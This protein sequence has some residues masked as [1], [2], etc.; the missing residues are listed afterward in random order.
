MP[1]GSVAASSTVFS[2]QGSSGAYIN[3]KS[4]LGKDAFLRLLV[5][6]LQNQ[7]PLKPMEDTEFVTQLAQFSALEQMTNVAQTQSQMLLAAQ[8]QAASQWIGSEVSYIDGE[9]HTATGVVQSVQVKD[10]V[11]KVKVDGAEVDWSS[12]VQIGPRS[13]PGA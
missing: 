12:V 13:T 9:G 3:P 7:D 11:V 6:Q 8:L 1:E 4:Q 5:A 10:G 2:A